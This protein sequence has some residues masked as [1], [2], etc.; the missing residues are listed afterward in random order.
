MKNG[1]NNKLINYKILLKN[2]GITNTRIFYL[3]IAILFILLLLCFDFHLKH[4]SGY[5]FIVENLREK[6]KPIVCPRVKVD[7]IWYQI[8]RIIGNDTSKPMAFIKPVEAKNF[9]CKRIFEKDEEYVKVK[10]YI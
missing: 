9:D 7:N 10:T 2:L 8:T 4:I 1:F 6:D 5:V 3:F